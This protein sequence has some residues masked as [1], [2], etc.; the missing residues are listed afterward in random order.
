MGRAATTPTKASL[1]GAAPVRAGRPLLA[2]A[3]NTIRGTHMVHVYCYMLGEVCRPELGALWDRFG[4]VW[5]A[6]WDWGPLGPRS[7]ELLQDL[8]G[9]ADAGLVVRADISKIYKDEPRAETSAVYRLT[10]SG[11]LRRRLLFREAPEA[12][13]VAEAVASFQKVPASTLIGQLGAQW[14]RAR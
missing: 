14:S 4:M 7:N 8:N 10:K 9:C 3:G 6:D 13:V 5:Y 12:R 1:A 11:K 2:I